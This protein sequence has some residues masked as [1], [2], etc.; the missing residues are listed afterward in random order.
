DARIRAEVRHEVV[1]DELDPFPAAQ[2]LVEGRRRL[3]FHRR[4]RPERHDTDDNEHPPPCDASDHVPLPR[5]TKALSSTTVSVACS[6]SR[7][8]TTCA[9][10]LRSGPG[11][12]P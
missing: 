1:D 8:G 5:L 10:R 7:R 12:T 3:A 2:A 9:R 11:R 6:V 4:A